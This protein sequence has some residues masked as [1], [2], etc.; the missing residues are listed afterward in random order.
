MPGLSG[1]QP[2]P[3][4]CGRPPAPNL[5]GAVEFSDV[6]TLLKEWITTISGWLGQRHSRRLRRGGSRVLEQ[7]QTHRRNGT[8]FSKS[9]RL[10]P[11]TL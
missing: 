3:A 4:G 2:E 1:S 7:E 5:A 9:G 10:N 8:H 11:A 6:K